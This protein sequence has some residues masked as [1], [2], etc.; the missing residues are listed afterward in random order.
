MWCILM[1]SEKKVYEYLDL[2]CICIF[3]DKRKDKANVVNINK[4]EPW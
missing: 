4:F 2:V 1:G 3:R